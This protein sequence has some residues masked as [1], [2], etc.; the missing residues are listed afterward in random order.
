MAI[1]VVCKR[2]WPIS[3]IH[4]I[5]LSQ[6][7]FSFSLNLFGVRLPVH[8]RAALL[9]PRNEVKPAEGLANVAAALTQA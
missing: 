4:Q 6:D 5:L 7:L 8:R 3:P 9:L 2:V 1:L